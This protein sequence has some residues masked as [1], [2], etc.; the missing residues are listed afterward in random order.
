M[1]HAAFDQGLAADLARHLGGSCYTLH[2]LRAE[3]LY[4]TVR[5]ELN[6]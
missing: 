6:P 3:S 5:G 2:D 1:E 4:E